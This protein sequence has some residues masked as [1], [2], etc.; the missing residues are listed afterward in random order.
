MYEVSAPTRTSGFFKIFSS[1]DNVKHVFVYL[2]K[3]YCDANGS[4]HVETTP[5]KMDTFGLD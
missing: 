1:F 3:S 5:Y 2:K 4:R